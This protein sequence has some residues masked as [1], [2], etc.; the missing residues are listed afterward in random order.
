MASSKFVPRI[1]FTSSQFPAY[2]KRQLTPEE[3]NSVLG[4]SSKMSW[5]Y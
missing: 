4:M 2:E 3:L 5:M 1:D